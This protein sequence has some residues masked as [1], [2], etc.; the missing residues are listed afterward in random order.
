[1]SR[2][3][4]IRT[5][6]VVGAVLLLEALC[7]TGVIKPLTLIAPSAMVVALVGLIQSGKITADVTKTLGN[8]GLAFVAAVVVGF[9]ARVLVHRVPRLRRAL[10]SVVASHYSV[11]LFV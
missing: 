11:A 5:A 8:V 4:W 6:I 9:V 2:A 10:G 3:G 7:R 1:M